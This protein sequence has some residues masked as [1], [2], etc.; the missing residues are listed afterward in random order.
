MDTLDDTN[1][2]LAA[3]NGALAAAAAE[4]EQLTLELV[5]NFISSPERPVTQLVIAGMGGSGLASGLAQDWLQLAVPVQVVRDYSL[6]ASLNDQTLVIASSFSGNTEETLS[7]AQEALDR[8]AQLAITS[9]GGK[10]LEM[11]KS[12]QINCVELPPVA[13]PR[14]GVFANLMSIVTICQHYGLVG[15]QPINELRGQ[16]EW[17]KSQTDAWLPEVP[18][19]DNY[20]KQI[21]QHAAG[22]SQVVFSCAKLSS[23]AYKWKISLN[24][25][26]KNV[27]YYNVIPEFDHNE[28]TG[29]TSHPTDKPFA[30]FQ[31]RSSFEHPQITKRFEVV[32][33][34]LS[35]NMPEPMNIQLQ[36]ETLLQQMLWGCVLA[37]FASTYLAL[38]NG[39]DPV[40][41]TLVE[42]LKKEL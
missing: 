7:C 36:G 35:G 24:E 18:T 9:R 27:A 15:D 41:P 42:E 14:L 5:Q 22:K 1:R 11:A 37:D 40:T 19:A 4:W 39:A 13:Q 20:A 34:L 8:G 38:L 31:L 25:T 32:Q 33:R 29:W 2:L 6:P 17:L 16:A 21:A 28:L 23:V 10:L 12:Q 26:G 30:V 3:D